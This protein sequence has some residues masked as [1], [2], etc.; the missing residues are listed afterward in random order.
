[1]VFRLAEAG[2]TGPSMWR[3]SLQF[4]RVLELGLDRCVLPQGK[5]LIYRLRSAHECGNILRC[6]ELVTTLVS[7]KV[8]TS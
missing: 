8:Y 3:E 2:S 7:V 4:R 6:W 5:Q 1:M